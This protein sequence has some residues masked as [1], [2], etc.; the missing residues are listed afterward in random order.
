MSKPELG[1]LLS[2]LTFHDYKEGNHLLGYAKAF[3]YGKFKISDVTLKP[4]SYNEASDN[5]NNYMRDFEDF[6]KSKSINMD[7]W[8][9]ILDKLRLF[10]SGKYTENRDIRYPDLNSKEFEKIKNK[11]LR[12]NDYTPK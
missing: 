6:L 1:A 12:L 10:A 3:G 5:I 9:Y 4:Q 8:Q 7:N 2:A 11:E